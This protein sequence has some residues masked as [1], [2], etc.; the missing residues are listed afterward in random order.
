[1]YYGIHMLIFWPNT[2]VTICS[3]FLHVSAF[4]VYPT[5]RIMFVNVYK[6]YKNLRILKWDDLSRNKSLIRAAMSAMLLGCWLYNDWLLLFPLTTCPAAGSANQNADAMDP[7]FWLAEPVVCYDNHTA[8]D[9]KTIIN[10]VQLIIIY[11]LIKW[12]KYWTFIKIG[13]NI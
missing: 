8:H 7:L 5:S 3:H 13:I 6:E 11:N 12:L 2:K 4:S 1:M 10:S 9:K